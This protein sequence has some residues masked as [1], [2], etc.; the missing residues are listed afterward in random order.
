[1]DM[2]PRKPEALRSRSERTDRLAVTLS[3]T[4]MLAVGGG[5][6]TAVEF[7]KPAAVIAEKFPHGFNPGLQFIEGAMMAAPGVLF[8]LWLLD[9]AKLNRE[10]SQLFSMTLIPAI[11]GLSYIISALVIGPIF[12]S[13]FGPADLMEFLRR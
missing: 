9:K 6:Q 4:V 12:H 8:A 2:S 1:M 3:S 7:L 5:A 11:G 10:D 13:L